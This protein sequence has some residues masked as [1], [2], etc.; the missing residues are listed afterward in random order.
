MNKNTNNQHFT[1]LPLSTPRTNITKMVKTHAKQNEYS[2]MILNPAEM[3]AE[4]DQKKAAQKCFDSVGLDPDSYRIGL[5]KAS[6]FPTD[7]FHLFDFC[8][9][10]SSNSD[11]SM[12]LV[13]A[14]LL[15]TF[16]L[17]NDHSYLSW[18]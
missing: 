15:Y 12:T 18:I 16:L 13:Y 5:T 14:L 8:S 10:L 6:N 9:L 17:P 7:F 4:K 1:R 11:L 3:T 2:Y